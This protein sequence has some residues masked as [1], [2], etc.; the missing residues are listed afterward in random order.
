MKNRERHRKGKDEAKEYQRES[1]T[2]R[3]CEEESVLCKPQVVLVVL[4]RRITR[5]TTAAA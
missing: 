1:D 2:K 3:E 5:G 4:D